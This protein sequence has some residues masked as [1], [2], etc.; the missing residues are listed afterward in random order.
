MG[1]RLGSWAM[2]SGPDIDL[3]PQVLIWWCSSWHSVALA[4]A[5]SASSSWW[6]SWTFS[7]R[8]SWSS[9]Q[10]KVQSCLVFGFSEWKRL[11]YI[12]QTYCTCCR[13]HMYVNLDNSTWET[14]AKLLWD[15][16]H[17]TPS[18]LEGRLQCCVIGMLWFFGTWPSPHSFFLARKATMLCYW[19]V[20]IL[21][22][23]LQLLFF[24][25][26]TS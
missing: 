14:R 2:T 24:K 7:G 18:S 23:D 22:S 3:M 15:D 17:P 8:C 21:A 5:S 6:C 16:P 20:V 19:D 1:T 11:Q 12:V 10:C 13:F 4:P 25:M 26:L 9:C